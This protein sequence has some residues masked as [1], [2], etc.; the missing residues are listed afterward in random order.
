MKFKQITVRCS[1]ETSDAVSYI[2]HEAGSMGE[3]FD[4]Y[5]EVK[6]V[7]DEKRWDYAD[8]AL[9]DPTVECTVSGFFTVE[10]DEAAV[11]SRIYALRNEAWAYFS[12]L[13]ATVTLIDSTEWENEWKKYYKPFSI[14]DIV[15]VP[16]WLE[17]NPVGGEVKVTLNPGLAFG[18]GMHETTSMCIE[19][20]Q[21]TEPSGKR[22][23][24]FGCG[25]GILGVCAAALGA[26]SVIFADND[27]QAIAATQYNCKINGITDPE[28]LLRD[29][30][31]MKIPADMVLANITADVLIA[32]EPII[33]SVL[34]CDGYA[35][36]SG[37]IT[38]KTDAVKQA[39]TKDFAIVKHVRK[40]EW[41]AFLLKLL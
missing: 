8:A 36:I 35:V 18:T 19:L 24:D 22:V 10:T 33:K 11:L 34:S 13:D 26:R 5:G 41:S 4:D 28:I 40:N 27:E 37:I 38:D 7:L 20:M 1:S 2:L 9:F 21:E 29:V 17:Y 25:S 30:R 23:L 3:V 12:A 14:G 32:V 31:E 6:K 16:E 39:Y 15:I